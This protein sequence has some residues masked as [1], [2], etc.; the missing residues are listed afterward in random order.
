MG[1]G[2]HKGHR[3][4][5]WECVGHRKWEWPLQSPRARPTVHTH[6]ETHTP[7]RAGA[8]G[9][10]AV[11]SPGYRLRLLWGFRAT[12]HGQGWAGRACQ[13]SAQGI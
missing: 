13:T 4:H 6:R 8:A 11:S 2:G 1:T 12:G 9:R 3:G 7:G 10:Q 5:R